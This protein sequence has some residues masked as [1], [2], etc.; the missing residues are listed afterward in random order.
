M[1][2]AVLKI[3]N[4]NYSIDSE[5][6]ENKNA[7]IMRWHDVCRTLWGSTDVK[8]ATVTVVNDNGDQV[9]GYKETIHHE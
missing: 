5:H 9:D 7:A 3:V 6:G 8:S 4:G 1:K 2:Y